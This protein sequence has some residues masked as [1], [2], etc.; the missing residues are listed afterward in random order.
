MDGR[1]KTFLK[2]HIRGNGMYPVIHFSFIDKDKGGNLILKTSSN[3]PDATLNDPE[4]RN[5]YKLS[6]IDVV[7]I[8]KPAY[9]SLGIEVNR[10]YEKYAVEDEDPNDF[11]IT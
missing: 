6:V 8:V 4:W 2:N 11:N 9:I 10:W 3:I 1:G 7:N 5:L